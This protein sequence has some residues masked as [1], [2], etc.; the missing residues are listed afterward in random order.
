MVNFISIF[1]M[2]SF[3]F[4]MAFKIAKRNMFP[5][6]LDL[7][8]SAVKLAQ[9]R[10][11]DRELELVAA[12]AMAIEHDGQDD[13]AKRIEAETPYK[14]ISSRDRADTLMTG[15]I[16]SIGSSVLTS[17]RET[18]TSSCASYSAASLAIR[19]RIVTPARVWTLSISWVPGT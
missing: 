9:L 4:N 19:P 2:F 13:L 12:G 5:I 15:Q 18:G 10:Q 6:G 7:G 17:E 11:V 14:I 8:S 3:S 16:T 1:F